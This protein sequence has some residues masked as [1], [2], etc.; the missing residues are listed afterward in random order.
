MTKNQRIG[1]GTFGGLCCVILWWSYL[2]CVH[3]TEYGSIGIMQNFFTRDVALDHPGWN[4][5]APWVRVARMDTRPTRVCVTT[6]SRAFNCRL[7][8]F[9]PSAF[10]EFVT[11]EGFRYYWWDNRLS[12]NWGYDDEYRGTKDILRGYGYSAQT[13]PFITVLREYDTNE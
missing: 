8:Q 5:S 3:Y 4:F 10:R 12:F 1:A 9:N 6:A 11:T 13:Y 2:F 7:V